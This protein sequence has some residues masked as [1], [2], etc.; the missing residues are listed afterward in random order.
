MAGS[1]TGHTKTGGGTNPPSDFEGSDVFRGE[2]QLKAL[3]ARLTLEDDAQITAEEVTAALGAGSLDAFHYARGCLKGLV[4]RTTSEEAFCHSADVAIRASDLGF[5]KRY[6]GT[7]LLHDTVEDRS[8]SLPDIQDQLREVADRF[9]SEIS[10]DVRA[11]TNIHGVILKQIELPSDIAFEP[12]ALAAVRDAVLSVRDGLPESC[13]AE[14]SREFHQT[15]YLLEDLDRSRSGHRTGIPP[16]HTV[17]SDLSLHAYRLFIADM[18]DDARGRYPGP[19]L[20]E[21]PITV[22]SLDI[23]DNL[24]SSDV[25]SRRALARV[26]FKAEAFLDGTFYLHR[27]IAESGSTEQTAFVLVYDYL[28]NNLVEQLVERVKALSLLGERRFER[29]TRYLS[30]EIVRLE[31]KFKVHHPVR[32]I[33]RLRDRIR[34]ANVD[35]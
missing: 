17:M 9:G 28:K 14:F 5:P 24:R 26:L 7:A 10:S 2:K 30:R 8:R 11:M 21:V 31:A 33:A 16:E 29:L 4:R 15:T 13:Q 35:R 27:S 12:G 23:I 18:A 19:C 20:H 6:I 25:S 34:E 3:S 1:R 32:E 22:K